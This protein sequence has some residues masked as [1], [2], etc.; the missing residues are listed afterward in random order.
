MV[1]RE[2]SYTVQESDALA[3]NKALIPPDRSVDRPIS[4]SY[5]RL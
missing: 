1:L 5:Q 2:L 4:S 3:L